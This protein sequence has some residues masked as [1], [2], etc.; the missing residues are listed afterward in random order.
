MSDT[1]KS[2][3]QSLRGKNRSR[4]GESRGGGLALSFR[5]REPEVGDGVFLASTST[6]IGAASLGDHVSIWFGSVVRADIAPI[7]IGEETNIQDHSVIHVADDYPCVIGRRVVVGHRALL[8][9]CM[10][11]DETLIGMGAII[12][13][14][15]KI[16]KGSIV[17]AGSLV[18]EGTRIAPGS[19]AMG[20]PAKVVRE[21][22][23]AEYEL[24]LHL[25][26]KYANLA[27]EY[28]ERLKTG[29]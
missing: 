20:S 22:R 24:T 29:T 3:P 14:G 5:G 2:K 9:G 19:V 15:A 8:H 6:I 1:A 23:P 27:Q 28:L 11:G 21:I 16:G 26:R 10:I 12:M 4:I 13:N 18:T 25:A 17:A 7:E